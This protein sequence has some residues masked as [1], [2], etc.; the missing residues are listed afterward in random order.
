MGVWIGIDLGMKRTGLAMTDDLCIIASPLETVET[1]HLLE[2]LDQ[3]I[4]SK[5]VSGIVVGEPRHADGTASDMTRNVERL[6]KELEKRFPQ[7][8]IAMEDERLT[9]RHAAESLV[10]SGIRKK[11]RR[12]KGMLDKVSAALI[13]QAWLERMND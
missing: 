2:R 12:E 9:S 3:L 10:R 8:M 6:C 11:K 13:L 5:P 4:A 7:L 1:R